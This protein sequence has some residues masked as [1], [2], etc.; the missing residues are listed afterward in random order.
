M[1]ELVTQVMEELRSL[2]RTIGQPGNKKCES[3]PQSLSSFGQ[4]GKMYYST[5]SPQ[6]LA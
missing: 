6:Y 3:R 4:G 5:F 2:Q 1:Q